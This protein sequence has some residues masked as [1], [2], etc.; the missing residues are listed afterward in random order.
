VNK[1]QQIYAIL[2]GRLSELML[3]FPENKSSKLL[4]GDDQSW[5]PKA[6]AEEKLE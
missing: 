3:L 1:T 5:F 4:V 6:T 2:T